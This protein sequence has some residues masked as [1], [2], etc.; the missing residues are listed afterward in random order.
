MADL[1]Q[2][3]QKYTPVINTIQ[4]FSAEGAKIDDVSLDGDKLHLKASVPSPVV[5]NRVWD[6]IK[7]VDSTYADLHHEIATTGST[8]SY[9]IQ[10]GDNLSKVSKHFYGD[11]NKY[12]KIAQAN[13]IADAN[14]ISAGQTITIPA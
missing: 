8:Q 14:K 13:N 5:A 3:K 10:S 6:E 11:A 9:T 7:K 2:L 4:S 1:N 12:Q